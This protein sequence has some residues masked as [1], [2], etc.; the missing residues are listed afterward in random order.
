MYV[1]L[2]GR[3]NVGKSSLLNLMLDQDIAVTSLV[4]GTTTDIVEKAIE[5]LPLR[6]VLFWIRR[7]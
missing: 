4:A 6:P 5:L 3:T 7:S 2:L 1:A